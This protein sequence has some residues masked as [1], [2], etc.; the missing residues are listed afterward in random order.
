M[1]DK[2]E[3]EFWLKVK[4]IRDMNLKVDNIKKEDKKKEAETGK[5]IKMILICINNKEILE[6]GLV[7]YKKNVLLRCAINIFFKYVV[8]T[9]K[10][11]NI[12]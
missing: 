5:V 11:Y 4:T 2:L 12:I 9:F 1:T 6:G 8:K 10:K 3:L 7:L